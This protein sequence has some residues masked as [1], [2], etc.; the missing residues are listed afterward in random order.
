MEARRISRTGN[1]LGFLS[2]RILGR[3]IGPSGIMAAI[4][5]EGMA[6]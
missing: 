3:F 2:R 6:A 5:E 1:G 4:D